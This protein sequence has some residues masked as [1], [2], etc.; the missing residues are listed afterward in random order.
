MF[1]ANAVVQTS[2]ERSEVGWAEY[3]IKPLSNL[4][5]RTQVPM[6]D[7]FTYNKFMNLHFHSEALLNV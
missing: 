1:N 3:M 7:L 5:L 6:S 4:P 2:K